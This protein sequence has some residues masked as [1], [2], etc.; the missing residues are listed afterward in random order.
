MLDGNHFPNLLSEFVYTRTYAR[1]LEDAKR[2]ETWPET[3]RR[4]VSYILKDKPVPHGLGE[5]IEKLILDFDVLGSMRALWCAGPA[6]DRDNV[7]GYNC[8]GEETGFITRQG[9]RR[10]SDFKDGDRITVLTHTGAWKPAVVRSYGRQQL[11]NVT[12]VRGS[13]RYTV[14]ATRDHQWVLDDGSRTK[15]LRLKDKLVRPPRIVADWDYYS[16]NPEARNY[17]AF[18][19]VYGD[20]TLVKNKDGEYTHSMVRLCGDDKVRFLERFQELGYSTSSPP[21]FGGDAMAYTDHYLKTLPTIEG[22]GFENVVAFVRGYLDADG[23]KNTNGVWPSPFNGIQASKESA[24][25]FIRRVFPAVGAYI[26]Q[27]VDTTGEVTNYGVRPKT[28]RFGLVLGFG[29]S[30][31]S[32]FSVTDIQESTVETVW[33]LEVEDDHSFVL[34]NGIVT[35]NCSFLPVDNLRAFSE[36]LAILMAG[37]GVGF[38]VERT[39]TDN[40]PVI[41]HPTGDAI[42]YIIQDSTEG[43]ADAVYFGMVQYHLGHRV[44]WNYSLIRAK[45]ER[46]HTKGGR[47]SGPEP[48]KRVLDFAGETIAGAAGRKLKPIE[49]HDIMCM[50][51]EIVMVGGF[52]RASL[53]SFSDVEDTEMRDAKDWS[54]GT[55][56][57]IRYMANNSAV[58]TDRPTE[59][60][61]WREW[62]SLAKSGSGERGFYIVSPSNVAKRGGE[63]RS[64]PCGEIL[65]RFKRANDPWTGAGGGGQFCNLTAAV[66]RPHDTLETMA[67]KVHAAT[68]LGVIQSSYTH[69]PYLRPAW[70]ELCLTGDTR[71]SLLNGKEEKIRDLV[72]RDGFWVYSYDIKTQKMVPGWAHSVRV[73]QRDAEL[74]RVTLDSGEFFDCTP[75]HPVLLK[76]GEYRQ[77]G[78]LAAGDSLR[79]LYR[80]LSTA[81]DEGKNG[82]IGYEMVNTG[83]GWEFTH[84]LT[85]EVSNRGACEVCGIGLPEEKHCFRHH[86]DFDKRNNEPSNLWWLTRAEHNRIHSEMGSEILT[87]LWKDP[88]FREKVRE[89]HWKYFRGTPEYDAMCRENGEFL[90]GVL[91]RLWEDS[92]YRSRTLARLG[93]GHEAYLQTDRFRGVQGRMLERLW[94]DSDF[95]EKF[96]RGAREGI[97]RKWSD[98]T[99]REK[100]RAVARD[101]WSPEFKEKMRPHQ[102]ATGKAY[103]K[104]N[105]LAYNRSA[106]GRSRSGDNLRYERTPEHLAEMSARSKKTCHEMWHVK[107]GLRSDSC[108]HCGPEN[109]KVLKVERLS[110]R[111]DVYDLT[112][113]T[114]HNF[115]L[116]CG[117]FV[118]N[119]DEDRLVGVDITGQCDNPALSG[120]EEAMTYLNALARSTAIIAAA[121]LKVNRPAA[122]TCG[123]PSGNS[124]QFVDCASGFHTRYAKYYHRHVRISSKDPLYH[125]VRD[126][127]VPLFKENGQEHLDDDKVDVWVAR[128][129]VKSPDG[130]KL[131]DHE[132]ALQQ[133]ER[134]RQIM[135]TWCGAKGHN[136]SATVYVRDEEWQEV[137]QWLWDHFDEV[138][139]LSF[140][141]YDG[142]AYRLAPY[143]EITEEEYLKS[144]AEMPRVRFDLLHRYETGDMGDGAREAACASGA[145]EV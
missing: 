133:L 55:F 117:V 39:F 73:T 47:A 34:P 28:S 95:V 128:F 19:Y 143:V 38:S 24:I 69:F 115:A 64:N 23:H 12:L 21:T 135:R 80:R 10:F 79:P 57:S 4:Y 52:R 26:T 141:N 59:E 15:E 88:A 120:D 112:V 138:T 107:R 130:A 49:A 48:L 122:I 6:M 126:Q 123:K 46:L 66:M 104:K 105:L 61:F 22:D 67:E 127:G 43:W 109:H 62:N 25:E 90:R 99:Y 68:W 9:V 114:H 124:S 96:M 75:N 93:S 32:T 113:D 33:C 145:C 125:L 81:D 100:M 116:S 8:M 86:A 17:W 72:G 51:A 36:A 142:G 139:G 98:E 89:S 140:L 91:T 16:S 31:N 101:L 29:D 132:R 18:G 85:A 106:Q 42:D 129:P 134:Y 45:G 44:N 74:V 54:K 3:V 118:H 1:W 76:T 63:F 137:G 78:S 37:T 94:S 41:A 70:K 102:S 58:Y 35:G 111:E 11:F 136:Q 83:D 77:A 56:P 108:A 7:C 131:R 97:R 14:R 121:T 71:I 82:R 103:G 65:L 144:S 20:G 119:C 40:L 87:A 27:E 2:R 84:S 53:I 110:H 50:I 30:E 5:K 13:S 92:E 60:V